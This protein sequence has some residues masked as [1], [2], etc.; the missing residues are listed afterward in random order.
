[1]RT[2]SLQRD[3]RVGANVDAQ[4]D[5]LICAKLRGVEKGEM[6]GTDKTGF[7]RRCIYTP[8]PGM[9]D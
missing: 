4:P 7:D 6:I 2:L 9:A 3:L 8:A 1:M 5:T